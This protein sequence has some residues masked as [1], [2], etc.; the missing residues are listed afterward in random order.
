MV[1]ARL[2]PYIPAI[3]DGDI[4][5]YLV[6]LDLIK[7]EPLSHSGFSFLFVWILFGEFL[8]YG[9]FLEQ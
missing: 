4:R 6:K 5:L 2:T 9:C 8:S 7:L 1:I 3:K